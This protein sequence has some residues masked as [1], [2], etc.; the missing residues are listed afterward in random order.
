MRT[1]VL[2]NGVNSGQLWRK[3]ETL[4]IYIY[5]Y[6]IDLCNSLLLGSTH[7]VT[8]HLPR[9]YNYVAVD[10]VSSQNQSTRCVARVVLR[11]PKSSNITIHLRSLD[12][13]PVKV[14]STYKIA[15]LCYHCHSSTAPSYVAEMMQ[16]KPSHTHNIRSSSYTMPLLNRPPYSM[17]TLDDRSLSF[18]SSSVWVSIPNDVRCALAM[19]SYMSRLKTYLFHSVYKDWTFSFSF[20]TLRMCMAWPRY[21]LMVFH[22][23]V[24]MCMQREKAKLKFINHDCLSNLML[25]Y[26]MLYIMLAYLMLFAALSNA[27]CLHDVYFSSFFCHWFLIMPF[28]FMFCFGLLTLNL[29]ISSIIIHHAQ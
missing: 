6:I 25:L 22:R 29:F 1:A 9:I 27:V 24:L 16:I 18:A 12:W 14:R 2:C 7:G 10:V 11:L 19:S 23:Y 3:N 4:Y 5:I 20:I 17:A 13:L 28:A 15:C 21:S 26:I 8:P